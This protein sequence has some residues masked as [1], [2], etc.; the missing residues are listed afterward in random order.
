MTD[1]TR[2]L[3]VAAMCL[4]IGA[5]IFTTC[6]NTRL[7]R[8]RDTLLINVRDDSSTII[9]LRKENGQLSKT[10][11]AEV[12]S[13]PKDALTDSI[14]RLHEV[15]RRQ[16]Q[17]IVT[18]RSKGNVVIQS[19]AITHIIR[20]T[21]KIPAGVDSTFAIRELTG[22]FQ[23]PWYDASVRLPVYGKG[24]LRLS[25]IDTTSIVVSRKGADYYISTFNRNPFVTTVG[26]RDIRINAKP[27]KWGIG[28][29]V[30]YYWNGSKFQFGFGVS[31]YRAIITW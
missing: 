20:D 28:P 2:V 13:F 26:I 6:N 3:M 16:A 25:L 15:T 23:N 10:K 9:S 17:E 21:V 27:K 7:K 1:K 24:E 19:D 14:L 31:V 22:T 18:L 12:Q 8:E 29:S 4:M 5:L 11:T 30:G